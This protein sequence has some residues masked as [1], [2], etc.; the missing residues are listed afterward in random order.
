MFSS[1]L[2]APAAVCTLPTH[3]LP[4]R[5]LCLGDSITRGTREGV[6]EAQTFEAVLTRWFTQRGAAVEILNAGIG[7]EQT[8]QALLRLTTDVLPLEPGIVTVMYG[9][10]DAA[11]DQGQ[12]APRLPLV[13]YGANLRAIVERLRTAGVHPILMTPP[14]LGRSFGYMAW[15]PYRERGP[16]CVMVDYVHA[17][18]EVAAA[19]GVSLVD[20][21]AAWAEAALLGTDI[22][23]LMTDG[24]HP[25]PRGHELIARTMFPVLA[26]VLGT[27]PHPPTT[28]A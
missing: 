18:R 1:A 12:A 4:A 15:S 24:C 19:E 28:Q 27:D 5:I 17:V 7:G 23:T 20:H 14:P 22:D 26:R 13:K 6:A 8:D 10:N 11:V 2:F 21:F 25:N 16:N 3:A 9:T